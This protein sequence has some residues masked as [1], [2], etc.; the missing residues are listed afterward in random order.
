[1]HKP[2]WAA[3]LLSLGASQDEASA[4]EGD[5]IEEARAKGRL[6]FCLQ[7]LLVSLSLLRR[8]LLVAPAQTLLVGYAV[9]EL[10]LKLHWW[11]V[12]PLRWSL[13]RD[14]FMPEAVVLAAT[15]GL[16]T[17]AGAA[18]GVLLVRLM[19][20]L[21]LRAAVVAMALLLARMLILDSEI[22]PA[23]LLVFGGLPLLFACLASHRANLSRPPA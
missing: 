14:L 21:G 4:I 17:L 12:V 20:A 5:L 1:M 10:A 13:R 9:Y 3:T 22:S 18:I 16:W 2:T 11:G 6:W 7:T 19:P 15:L 23:L 8:T